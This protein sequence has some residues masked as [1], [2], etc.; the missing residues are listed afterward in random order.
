MVMLEDCET[1]ERQ[2]KLQQLH[3]KVQGKKKT[4]QQMEGQG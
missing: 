4:S 3:W 2:N 1:E